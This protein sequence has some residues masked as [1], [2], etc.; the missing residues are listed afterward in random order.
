MSTGLG[1]ENIVL[2]G[3]TQTET[4]DLVDSGLFNTLVAP[5]QQD[6]VTDEAK[7]LIF[8]LLS[9]VNWKSRN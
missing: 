1:M 7:Q 5:D 3:Q 8:R 4:E 6:A 9:D 2:K